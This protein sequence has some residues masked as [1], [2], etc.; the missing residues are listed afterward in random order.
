VSK[1]WPDKTIVGL[2]GNIATGKSAVMR[3]AAERGALALDADRL[4]H[5]ILD[6]DSNIQETIAD[7]F[8]PEIR[9]ADGRI[10]RAAL[11]TI[12]FSN[13][14]ALRDLERM[15]HPAV[16][17]EIVRQVDESEANVVFIE[18]IKLLEGGLARECDQVWVTRCPQYYQIERLMVCRGMDWESAS[19]RVN[20]QSPQEDKVARADVVIDTDGTLADTLAQFE[21]AWERLGVAGVVQAAAPA[22]ARPVVRPEVKEREKE[23][24]REK[25]VPPVLTPSVVTPARPATPAAAEETTPRAAPQR[26]SAG[27]AGALRDRLKA[28]S[29]V[30]QTAPAPEAETPARSALTGDYTVRRA[31]PSDIPSILLLIQRSTGGA[32]KIKRAELLEALSERSY[33]IGQSGTEISTV[34]GWNVDNLVGRIDQIYIYPLEATETTGRAVLAEVEESADKHICEA[35]LAFPSRS[36]PDA[37]YRLFTQMGYSPADKDNLART[38]Q[39][40]VDESQPDDTFI[41]LKVLRERPVT[42]P[43]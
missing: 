11:G 19:V 26:L 15:V 13:A 8:G 22:A 40:A 39:M 30:A 5:E 7:V 21:L 9:K 33:F 37:I 16:R 25:E 29:E 31:R 12:V 14:E 38:W 42:Q 28:K 24:E 1:R 17:S 41:L 3:L 4:V 34:V 10:N 32:V 20:A 36:T 18:A 23:R 27:S 6:T 43:M 2:T 35:I